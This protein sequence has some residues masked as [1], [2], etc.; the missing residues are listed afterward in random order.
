MYYLE[1]IKQFLMKTTCIWLLSLGLLSLLPAAA[2]QESPFPEEI[3]GSWEGSGQLFG[4][5]AVFSMTWERLLGG[6]FLSLA[7]GNRFTDRSGV[8]RTLEARAYY[9]LNTRQG[10]WFDSRGSILPLLFGIEGKTMTVFWGE[11]A[12]EKGKTTYTL[13]P[14]GVQVE[15]FVFR[16]EEYVSFGKAEYLKTE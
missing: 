10:Y 12:T 1:F 15:D 14:F 2:Q 8:E 9:N 6:H 5:E 7:F 16:G 11:E 3:R 13:H 4:Q